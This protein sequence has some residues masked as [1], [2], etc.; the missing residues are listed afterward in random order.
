MKGQNIIDCLQ[1]VRT[2]CFIYCKHGHQLGKRH[3]IS[4]VSTGNWTPYSSGKNA[5]FSPCPLCRVTARSCQ[6]T[7]EL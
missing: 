1:L 7:F 2:F 5:D 3:V 4:F 6:V